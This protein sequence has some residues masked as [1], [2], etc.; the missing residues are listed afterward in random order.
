MRFLRPISFLALVLMALPA[1]AGNL[2]GTWE[3]SFS[4]KT[5]DANGRSTL[6]E[7]D[8]TLLISQPNAGASP[9]RLTIDG[10][11]YTGSIVPSATNPTEVGVGAFVACGTSDT[12]AVGAFNEIELIRW[13]VDAESGTGSIS[14]LGVFVGNGQGIGGCKGK[15]TRLTTAN[16]NIPACP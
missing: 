7:P 14:K 3:G 13:K 12:E 6:R 10:V 2:I 15:W 16:P 11:Q 5:E 1:A 9:L 8:S 4:C